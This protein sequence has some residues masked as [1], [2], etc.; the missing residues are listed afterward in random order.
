MFHGTRTLLLGQ[1]CWTALWVRQHAG[2]LHR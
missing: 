2:S 1:I